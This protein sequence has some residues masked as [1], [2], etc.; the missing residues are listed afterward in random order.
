[1][2]DDAANVDLGLPRLESQLEP[3]GTGSSSLH[4]IL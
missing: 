2:V 4:D 1:M 3:R